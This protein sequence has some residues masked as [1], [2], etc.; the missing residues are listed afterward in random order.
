MRHSFDFTAIAILCMRA[1]GVARSCRRIQATRGRNVGWAGG[2]IMTYRCRIVLVYSK[3]SDLERIQP[4]SESSSSC[5]P[6]RIGLGRLIYLCSCLLFET[7]SN[8]G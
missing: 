1:H 8:S 5:S 4:R 3:V 2:F 6:G 7:M